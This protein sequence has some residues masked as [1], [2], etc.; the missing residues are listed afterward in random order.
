[1]KFSKP[2]S[3]K[4]IAKRFNCEIIGNADLNAT[5]INEIH[6]VE[7]DDITFVDL[8]KYYSKSINSA[9]SIII[10]DKKA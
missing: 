6:K 4:E 1:M 10:I 9:A 3:I 7:K 2:I 8:D 5:G